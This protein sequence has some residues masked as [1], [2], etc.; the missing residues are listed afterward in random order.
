MAECGLNKKE[1]A[2]RVV[3]NLK[4]QNFQPIGEK[5][6]VTLDDIYNILT[7]NK[8][9]RLTMN[10]L[11]T[12][13]GLEK[14][15]LLD[16]ING[17]EIVIWGINDLAIDVETSLIKSNLKISGHLHSDPERVQK[18]HINR[19]IISTTHFFGQQHNVKDD[20]FI[21]I[22]TTSFASEAIEICKDHGLRNKKDFLHGIS[23][24]RPKAIIEVV[25]SKTKPETNSYFGYRCNLDNIK[26][27]E[28]SKFIAITEKLD[29]DIP[30]LTGIEIGLFSDA[31][32]HT[33]IFELTAYAEKIAPVT[34][35]TMLSHSADIVELANSTISRV[36]IFVV[37]L[38]AI[39]EEINYEQWDNFVSR[40]SNFLELNFNSKNP[41]RINVTVFNV[42][43]KNDATSTMFLKLRS[44][45]TKF[46]DFK[47]E[48]PY[49]MPYDRVLEKL[50][51]EVLNE[52]CTDNFRLLPYD[53]TEIATACLKQKGLQCVSQRIFPI[54]RVDCSVLLC[55]LYAQPTVTES[56]FDINYEDLVDK[57]HMHNHCN[58]CQKHGLHR[59]D[60]LVL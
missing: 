25:E 49:L 26:Q 56:Y 59:F 20:Y 4:S 27:I 46:A 38:G 9:K 12:V 55:H 58:S 2:N 30:L 50:N 57:R 51:G 33:S 22:G 35:K 32:L 13:Q 52:K 16:L 41:S 45:L 47:F 43:P 15:E 53:L 8:W 14:N 28:N 11:T 21:I 48:S 19:K 3:S 18:Q 36:D 39:Y 31:L 40:L 10:N 44:K 5:F 23:I 7:S 54:I 42:G 60:F 1:V 37:G 34:I 29:T 17:R 6:D 24:K